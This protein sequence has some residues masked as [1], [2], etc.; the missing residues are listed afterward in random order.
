MTKSL[1]ILDRS[2]TKF[3]ESANKSFDTSL[4]VQNFSVR[5]VEKV[6]HIDSY[7]NIQNY[8]IQCIRSDEW[9][10]LLTIQS[11]SPKNVFVLNQTKLSPDI[12]RYIHTF[13]EDKHKIISE[14]VFST[15]YPF[16]PHQCYIKSAHSIKYNSEEGKVCKQN[17][18]SKLA[19]PCSFY[20][21]QLQDS[22]MTS[23]NFENH[24]LCYITHILSLL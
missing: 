7:F 9:R 14:I 12:V 2:Y 15:D 4:N 16:K 17:I 24:I 3:V 19:L 22:W 10:F 18:R 20:N 6:F 13:L 8:S 1:Q 11:E 5:F 23:S 21:R